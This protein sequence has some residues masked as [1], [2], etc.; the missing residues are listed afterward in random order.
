MRVGRGRALYRF[1][2]EPG[3]QAMSLRTEAASARRQVAV[4]RRWRRRPNGPPSQSTPAT[5]PRRERC[6]C[7]RRASSSNR[8]C[9]PSARTLRLLHCRARRGRLRGTLPGK[10]ENH[11]EQQEMTDEH[12]QHGAE[13]RLNIVK[14]NLGLLSLRSLPNPVEPHRVRHDGERRKRHRSTCRYS[15]ARTLSARFFNL[16]NCNDYVIVLQQ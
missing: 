15:E 4:V 2:S 5:Y 12:L 9:R 13:G 7:L 11:S 1:R 6:P 14:V 10:A 8:A 16:Q 3:P